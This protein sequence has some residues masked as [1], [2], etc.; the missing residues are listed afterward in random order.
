MT[1]TAGNEGEIFCETK[2]KKSEIAEEK[3]RWHLHKRAIKLTTKINRIVCNFFVDLHTSKLFYEIY[4]V[5]VIAIYTIVVYAQRG[6]FASCRASV[7]IASRFGPPYFA[8][9]RYYKT[10]RQR[11]SCLV[12]HIDV[13]GFGQKFSHSST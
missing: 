12:R 6:K 2:I 10:L 3:N 4:Q 1:S 13:Q 9:N 11:P 5:I 7:G 8:T